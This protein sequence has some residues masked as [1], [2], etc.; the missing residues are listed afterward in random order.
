VFDD[1]AY[2]DKST[3]N[4]VKAF[5][6]EQIALTR[7]FDMYNGSRELFRELGFKLLFADEIDPMKRRYLA[8][9]LLDLSNGKPYR[10]AFKIKS[11]GRPYDESAHI[12]N[13]KIAV[14]IYE[15]MQY[16][17]SLEKAAV[18]ICDHYN[19]SE[20]TAQKAYKQFSHRLKGLS[21]TKLFHEYIERLDSGL[22]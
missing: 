7:L 1:P 15:A 13:L 14:H 12:R 18:K 8:L 4:D 10:E 20:H 6:A 2:T 17:M 22:G 5:I 19:V 9:A 21:D 3:N 11:L 16:G